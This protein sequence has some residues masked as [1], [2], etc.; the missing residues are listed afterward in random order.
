MPEHEPY[1]EGGHTVDLSC[2]TATTMRKE[3]RQRERPPVPPQIPLGLDQYER[4]NLLA[5]MAAVCLHVSP[6]RVA[7]NGD[8]AGQILGK[9]GYIGERTDWGRPNVS[10]EQMA[11]N[12]RAWRS[13]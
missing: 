9:L 13:E 8:W 6:L 1:C 12:A 3:A 4:D 10:A 7:N 2:S 11:D 5:L